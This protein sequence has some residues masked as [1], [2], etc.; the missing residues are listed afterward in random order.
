MA[1]SDQRFVNV[2]GGWLLMNVV[3]DVDNVVGIV[4]LDV[5]FIFF[6]LRFGFISCSSSVSYKMR[7]DIE[8]GVEVGNGSVFLF[9]FFSNKQKEEKKIIKI[10]MAHH[11]F[12]FFRVF[13]KFFYLHSQVVFNLEILLFFKNC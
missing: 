10:P 2:N 7:F 12:F 4:G 3:V 13:L 1:G 6:C 8:F 5:T 9:C 11:I